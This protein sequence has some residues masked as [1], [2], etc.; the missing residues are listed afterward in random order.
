VYAASGAVL[1]AVLRYLLNKA[2]PTPLAFPPPPHFP[3]GGVAVVSFTVGASLFV[4]G[5]VFTAVRHSNVRAFTVGFCA[6]VASLS[7]S[8]IIGVTTVAAAGLVLLI[9]API[10]GLIGV[11]AG[12][13]LALAFRAR[14]SAVDDAVAE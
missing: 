5:F 8:V 4:I 12:A 2:W 9:L 7:Q 6:G 13:F 14:T 3:T 1:G 11:S 10:C